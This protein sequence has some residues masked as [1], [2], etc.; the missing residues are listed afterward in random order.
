M[1][2]GCMKFAYVPDH[3]HSNKITRGYLTLN[4]ILTSLAS[5]KTT[6]EK[7]A[8]YPWNSDEG[9][10]LLTFEKLKD[11]EMPQ[12]GV[13]SIP[14]DELDP[15]V[16]KTLLL[17]QIPPTMATIHLR[18]MTYNQQTKMILE[19]LVQLKTEGVLRVLKNVRLHFLRPVSPVEQVV[20]GLL[21]GTMSAPGID[22]LAPHDRAELGKMFESAGIALQV[23]HSERCHA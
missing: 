23:Y 8:L 5:S 11:L 2:S 14:V 16:I 7:L 1:T 15:E 19:Q 18:Y 13:L 20:I 9:P 21:M 17:E 22:R 4:D 12:P 3:A 6:L 10:P